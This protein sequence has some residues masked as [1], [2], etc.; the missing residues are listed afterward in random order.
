MQL[1]KNGMTDRAFVIEISV[2]FE[3]D[4]SNVLSLILRIPDYQN[5]KSF[6][7]QNSALSF[8][9]K[10]NLLMDMKELDKKAVAKLQKFSEIRNKFAHCLEIDTFI[11]CYDAIQGCYGFLEKEYGNS[12]TK[13]TV[14]A[15]V[16]AM[17]LFEHLWQDIEMILHSARNNVG[18]KFLNNYLEGW[19]IT[20]MKILRE[21]AETEP[22]AALWV[23]RLEAEWLKRDGEFMS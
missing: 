10:I 17:Q 23:S 5:S 22:D 2:S 12:L 4:L 13:E 19:E 1:P 3:T 11:K 21:L 15:D 7:N 9:H 6:G 18:N 20:K 16:Y 14:S 8:N